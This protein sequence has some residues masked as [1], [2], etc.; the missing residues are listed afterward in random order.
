VAENEHERL[1][2]LFEY[3]VQ[4][5]QAMSEEASQESLGV[6][7]GE[8][9]GLVY[10]GF[11]TKLIRELGLP[12]PYYTKVFGELQRMDCV[13]QLRRGG[14]TTTSR[15]LLLQAPTPELYLKM[16]LSKRAGGSRM[17]TLEQ[18]VRDL[19]TRVKALEEIS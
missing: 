4:A 18:Q 17:D 7:Y 2:A 14:S 11:T 16:P 13:R 3:C 1:P 9:E 5:Y 10:D 19:N 6:G 15:W 12:V 8:E